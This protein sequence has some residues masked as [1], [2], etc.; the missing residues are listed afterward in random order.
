MQALVAMTKPNKE[1]RLQV[2]RKS[3]CSPK[4]ISE[5]FEFVATPGCYGLPAVNIT[6]I[7]NIKIAVGGTPNRKN[8]DIDRCNA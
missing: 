2:A 3:S 8:G 6:S 7:A 1:N 4:S 5:N